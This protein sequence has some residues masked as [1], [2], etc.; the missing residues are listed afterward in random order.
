MTIPMRRARSLASLASLALP[1]V[2]PAILA[3]TARADTESQVPTPQPRSTTLFAG[4]Q[5]KI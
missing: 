2:L 5:A 3:V 4:I 1:A